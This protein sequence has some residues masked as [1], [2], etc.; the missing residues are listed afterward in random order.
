MAIKL[1][2]KVKIII[3]TPEGKPVT[4]AIKVLQNKPGK[5]VGVELDELAPYGHSLDGKVEERYDPTRN[6]T[7]GKGWWTLEGNI[8]PIG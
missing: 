3:G 5:R 7:L 1:N 8:E 6:I 4:G 2:D